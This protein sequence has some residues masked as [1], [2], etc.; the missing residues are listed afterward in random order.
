MLHNIK[1]DQFSESNEIENGHLLV[2]VCVLKTDT[3][4]FLTA[5]LAF[6]AGF[7]GVLVI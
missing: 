3:Q 2:S 1:R 7:E 5:P 6:D 4:K